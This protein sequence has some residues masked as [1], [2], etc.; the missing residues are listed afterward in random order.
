VARLPAIARV[1]PGREA[2]LGI[3][4]PEVG[5]AGEQVPRRGREGRERLRCHPRS[6]PKEIERHQADSRSGARVQQEVDLVDDRNEAQNM[7]DLVESD[8]LEAD[9]ARCDAIAVVVIEGE[10]GVEL[11]G[12]VARAEQSVEV[13]ESHGLEVGLGRQQFPVQ[14][15]SSR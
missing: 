10:A 7:A 12:A 3:D 4:Q 8:R 1:N 11:D 2:V 9:R 14:A 5:A 15:E 6:E 13:R